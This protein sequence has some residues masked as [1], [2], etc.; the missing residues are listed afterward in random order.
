MVN[1]KRGEASTR[2]NQDGKHK[3]KMSR[4]EAG[5]LGG[6][7][8]HT[9]RGRQCEEAHGSTSNRSHKTKD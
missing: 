2:S 1:K 3:G 9:C 7:A 8:P 5:H 4:K 6:V